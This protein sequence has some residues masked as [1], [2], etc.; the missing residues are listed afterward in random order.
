MK[1]S[2]QVI[3]HIIIIA[4]LIFLLLICL[5]QYGAIQRNKVLNLATTFYYM[6]EIIDDETESSF[7]NWE[8]KAESLY[9]FEDLIPQTESLGDFNE[10]KEIIHDV[11]QIEDPIDEDSASLVRKAKEMKIAWNTKFGRWNVQIIK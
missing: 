11:S 2:K 6:Q 5:L 7:Q 4:V 8:K 9:R 10:I 3:L 1:K